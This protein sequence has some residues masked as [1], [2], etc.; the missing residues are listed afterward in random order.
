MNVENSSKSSR[1][2]PAKGVKLVSTDSYLLRDLLLLLK[3]LSEMDKTKASSIEGNSMKSNIVLVLARPVSI[4][5]GRP[6]GVAISV[7]YII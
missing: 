3:R 2:K 6:R 1:T 5:K 4:V 7:L